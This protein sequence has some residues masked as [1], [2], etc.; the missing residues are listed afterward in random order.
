MV[1]YNTDAARATLPNDRR[2]TDRDI[3]ISSSD[4][5]DK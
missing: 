4:D 3:V 1:L 5:D 2:N